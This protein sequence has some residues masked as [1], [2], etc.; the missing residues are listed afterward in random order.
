MKYYTYHLYIYIHILKSL[1]TYIYIGGAFEPPQHQVRLAQRAPRPA[2]FFVLFI[3]KRIHTL[4][5]SEYV[6][7]SIRYRISSICIA[8]CVCVCVCE[9]GSVEPPQHQVRLAQR[10]PRPLHRRPRP[11]RPRRRAGPGPRRPVTILLLLLLLF[12]FYYYYYYCEAL[13]LVVR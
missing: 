5:R 6:Y 1:F 7:V 3:S 4:F 12:Y 11:L 2:A 9:G 13:G 10:A 8:E